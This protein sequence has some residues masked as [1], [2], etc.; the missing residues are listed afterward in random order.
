MKRMF[1]AKHKLMGLGIAIYAVTTGL[2]TETAA[3]IEAPAQAK[4]AE[5]PMS[6]RSWGGIVRSGSGENYVR[7][8]SL[9]EGEPVTILAR[10]GIQWNAYEWFRIRYHGN[11]IG[12]AW[13]GILC[14]IGMALQGAFEVC[15]VG[16]AMRVE[17]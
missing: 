4:A 17:K 2:L 8:A 7:L 5:L 12:Y 16:G 3:A 9:K 11:Q 13:G 6:A 1:A 10:T 14:P 15:Q